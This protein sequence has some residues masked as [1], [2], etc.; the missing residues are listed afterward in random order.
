MKTLPEIDF[1][2]M[3]P[4]DDLRARI[5]EK[6]AHLEKL[7][8]R[9]TACRVAVRG[10]GGHHRTG[11]HWDFSIRL[12]LPDGR[13]VDVTRAADPDERFQ[14]AFFALGDAFRRADRQLEDAVRDM[15]GAV[16]HHDA[17][18][19][20]VV[21]S[22]SPADGFGLLESADGREIYFHRNS[23]TG[24]GF[25]SLALGERV[26]FLE[27]EGAKGPQARRVKPLREGAV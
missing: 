24:P 7:Y 6:I 5:E 25:D 14:D 9:M 8:G 15:R 21:K 11:G 26:T 23:V 12:A 27:E 3:A 1:Q 18:L 20:G 19:T 17:A 16:K 22:L 13:E 2:G 10:P 4:R